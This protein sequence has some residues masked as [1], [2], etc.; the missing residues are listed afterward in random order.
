MSPTSL[1]S[2]ALGDRS[3]FPSLE[4]SAYLNHA[5]VSPPSLAVQEALR[6]VVADYARRGLG[7]VLHWQAQRERLRDK[8]ARLIG[9]TPNEVALTTGTTRGISDVALSLPWNQGDRLVLLS[10]EFPANVTPWLRAARLFG[11][12]PRWLET[13]DFERGVGLDRL[14]A[15]LSRGARLVAVSAV[16]F[17]SGFRMPL[18]AI[19]A[20]CRKH[21]AQL[22]VDAI[23]ALGVVD[24]DVER[25]AIDYLSSGAHKWLMGVEG[26]GLLYV[27]EERRAELTLP[28]AGWLSHVDPV[29]FLRDGPGHLRYDRPLVG[30]ARAFEGGAYNAL[31]LAALEPAL[32]TL[33]TL[34]IDRIFAHVQRY[35]DALEPQLVARGFQTR[36]GSRPGERSGSLCFSLPPNLSAP[37]LHAGLSSRGI[38]CAIPDGSLRFA[39]HFPNSLD[40]VPRVVAAV[41]EALHELA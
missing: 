33:T 19:G 41:D 6:E 38:A 14:E 30:N 26:A 21:G 28:I 7:A 5:G 1:P 35:H 3:L 2:P 8:C 37:A 10:G 9:A 34:G 40:E 16:Q 11:L 17:Q 36:R 20:L 12:E 24:V 15:T 27:R 4:A 18:E 32:D 23:Q 39:P 22:C 25:C 31:G 29:S 13:R